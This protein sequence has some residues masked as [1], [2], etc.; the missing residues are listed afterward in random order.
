MSTRLK[1]VITTLASVAIAMEIV[2]V[3]AAGH[4]WLLM[5]R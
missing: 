3:C 2:I 4:G 5:G 1:L